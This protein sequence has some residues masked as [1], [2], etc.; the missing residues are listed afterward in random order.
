MP[1]SNASVNS[2]C[3]HPPRQLRGIC[4]HCQSRESG[5]SLP[6]CYPRAFDTH[7]VSDSKSEGGRFYRKR[8][9]ASVIDWLL[10]Q[11]LDQIVEVFKG[12]FPRFKAFYH[13]LSIY[14]LSYHCLYTE[15]CPGKIVVIMYFAFKTYPTIS[16]G[17]GI[18][19]LLSSPLNHGNLPPKTKKC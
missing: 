14:N 13:C 5:I 16:R 1:H 18:Y 10:R 4:T 19:P 12:M 15:A 9:V 17:R 8:P 11:G 7:V 6:K 3:A 2:R